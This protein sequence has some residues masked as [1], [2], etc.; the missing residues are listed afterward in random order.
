MNRKSLILTLAVLTLTVTFSLTP[1]HAA[2]CSGYR[3]NDTRISRLFLSG[4]GN[5]YVRPADGGQANL[6]CGSGNTNA[7][8]L[9]LTRAHKSFKE[10]YATLLA[11]KVANSKV[12]FRLVSSGPSCDIAYITVDRP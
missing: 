1:A 4:D 2:P 10:I 9:V 7:T 11:I 5:V 6:T 3:C 12:N 8:Y